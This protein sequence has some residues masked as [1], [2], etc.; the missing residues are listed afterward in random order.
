MARIPLVE[1]V[2]A[3]TETGVLGISK[4]VHQHAGGNL[5]VYKAIGNHP[6][7][8]AALLRFAKVVYAENALPPAAREIAYLATSV[9]NDCYY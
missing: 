2:P 4:G 5:N 8:L 6:E 7:A 9:A 3:S 1:A